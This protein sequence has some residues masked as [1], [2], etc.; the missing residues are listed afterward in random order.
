MAARS[1]ILLFA[2]FLG[3]PYRA[4]PHVI[5]DDVTVQAFAK[6]SGDR[7]HLLVRVPFNALAD[8]IFPTRPSGDLDLQ[9]TQAM[10]P[11][12][13]KT[14]ISDWIDLYEGDRLL[15]KPR[16]VETRISLASDNSF[17][18]YGEA[19]EHVTGPRLPASV[20]VFPNQAMLDVLLDYPIQSDH[21]SFAIHSRLA[22]LGV[23]VVTTLQFIPPN[24]L[25]R[26][27]GYLGD[28]GLFRLDPGWREAVRRFVP[29]G[30]LQI[31]KGSD[32]LLFLF[33]VALLFRRWRALVPFVIAFAVA[34]SITLI[35]SAYNLAPDAL[36]FPVFF[37]TLIALSIV[38]LAIESI[39]EGTAAQ[40]RWMLAAGFG[41][42]YG[43]GFSFALR[44]ALQFGGAHVLASILSFNLGIE[45]AQAV[46]L[47]LFVPMLKLFFSLRIPE[48]IGTIFLAALAAH[49]GWHRMLDRAKWLRS[50]QFQWPVVDP[51]R[52]ST[53]LR[54]MLIISILA[55]TVYAVFRLLRPLPKPAR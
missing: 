36:W 17:L 4:F 5:P 48:R 50:A 14:W 31:W 2:V 12:A 10:L 22:R 34:H 26:T 55:G 29:L 9:P 30:F 54:W 18:S 41:L 21:S 46:A 3:V 52:L 53:T 23:R 45:L 40:N 15:P 39:V 24:G 20:Q 49:A 19:L 47:L 43:F 6:P 13:A 35:A 8:L 27:Y 28:P 44:Q 1:S 11:D 16:I 38:Y 37:E 51:A 33:C 32:Y 7:L 42:V 25:V